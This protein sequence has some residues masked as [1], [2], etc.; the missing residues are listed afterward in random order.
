MHKRF[1]VLKKGKFFCRGFHKTRCQDISQVVAHSNPTILIAKR[2]TNFTK[3]EKF[4]SNK[5]TALC[6]EQSQIQSFEIGKGSKIDHKTVLLLCP[7]SKSS[8]IEYL[9]RVWL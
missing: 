1:K 5:I 4:K 3:A 7:R 8:I 6:N 9:Q 2:E